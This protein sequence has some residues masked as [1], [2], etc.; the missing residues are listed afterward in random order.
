[1]KGRKKRH[2][3]GGFCLTFITIGSAYYISNEFTD[4][5]IAITTTHSNVL[6]AVS[7]TEEP[8]TE[9]PSTEEPSTEEPSTEQPST[10]EPSTEE[11]ST[12][13][14]STEEP[15]TEEPSTEQPSTED[16]STEESSTEQPSTEE[17][18]TEEPSTEQPPK[19]PKPDGP[20]S[21]GSGGT[22][23]GSDQAPPHQPGDNNQSG[24]TVPDSNYPG[25]HNGNNVSNDNTNG[26][27][28]KQGNLIENDHH[29]LN[30]YQHEWLSGLQSNAS[31]NDKTAVNDHFLLSEEYY[32]I[33]D[34]KMLALMSG[35]M[36]SNDYRKKL[37]NKYMSNHHN[38]DKVREINQNGENLESQQQG[39]QNNGNHGNLNMIKYMGV[40][41]ASIIFIVV[42]SMIIWKRIRKMN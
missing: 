18:S 40:A 12:E 19:P 30:P 10:E 31:R 15:S 5:S 21:G 33:L 4:T 39:K 17:P 26:S 28:M 11:P 22:N 23:Q 7:S 36:G 34:R 24:P 8:S 38:E 37:F 25:N 41:L 1:M 35:E 3:F 27:Y 13:E 14:P 20:S 32:Q 6:N 9:Q 2:I 29:M 16:P 42:F